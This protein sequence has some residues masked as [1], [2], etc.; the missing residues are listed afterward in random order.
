MQFP[1]FR[2]IF[3]SKP[4]QSRVC[5]LQIE[6]RTFR[7]SVIHLL[8]NVNNRI[9]IKPS[10]SL[11]GTFCFA[12]VYQIVNRLGYASPCL[13]GNPHKCLRK[14]CYLLTLE[15]SYPDTASALLKYT[16]LQSQAE[17]TSY[18]NLF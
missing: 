14:S 4:A 3:V 1:S 17:F 18:R 13:R 10:G 15:P 6:Y 12:L 16:L 7:V 8:C 2:K 9:V 5:S 11:V